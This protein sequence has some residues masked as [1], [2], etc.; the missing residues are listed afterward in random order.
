MGGPDTT[1]DL[2]QAA[3]ADIRQPVVAVIPDKGTAETYAQLA[4]E[5]VVHDDDTR[6]DQHLA[7]R[8]V[9][10]L[11]EPA[12]VGQAIRRVLQQQR[13]GT[14]VDGHAA[15]VG[16]Q[17]TLALLDQPGQVGRL[18]VI[19]LQVFRAHRSQLGQRLVGFELLFFTSR[20]LFLRSNV[21]HVAFLALIEP[22]GS[23]HDV[24]R[25]VPRHV[26]QA[27]RDIAP[28]RIADHDVLAAGL[29]QQLQDG[30]RFDV[31]EIQR[32]ALALE[33]A[34][35]RVDDGLLRLRPQLE[36]VIAV[37]L[38]GK[39]VKITRR[40][41]DDTSATDTVRHVER[42][43]W[44]REIDDVV[45]TCHVGSD[46]RAR[47]IHDHAAAFLLQA[48][49]YS[50]VTGAQQD[51][52]GAVLAAPEVDLLDRPV[53]RRGRS[54]GAR[55]GRRGPGPLAERHVNVVA[56][57]SRRIGLQLV[58]VEHDPRAPGGFG[59]DDRVDTGRLDVDAARFEP[60]RSSR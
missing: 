11:H 54:R 31:L 27:Q 4:A 37:G 14:L 34:L 47:E 30:S 16:Q 41:D 13:I 45:A 8:N 5:I 50:R 29:G 6:F 60:E 17:R 7:H 2:V 40:R 39:L 46:G 57:G 21:N 9:E 26:L 36:H 10:R 18:G 43:H 56:F 52:A 42:T 20:Q 12:N 51:A 38:V 1:G 35:R 49:L 3:G 28:H 55:A 22:L 19:D 58:E 32:Q 44:R 59:G 33:L 24:E 53:A 15:A 48:R 23:Q 25:L